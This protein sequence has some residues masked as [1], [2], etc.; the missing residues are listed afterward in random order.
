MPKAP[1][2]KKVKATDPLAPKGDGSFQATFVHVTIPTH[3]PFE[4]FQERFLGMDKV[5]HWSFVHELGTK[6]IP[7]EH[8]H[9]LMHF[10]KQRTVSSRTFDFGGQHG[11]NKAVTSLE[12]WHNTWDYHKKEHIFLRQSDPMMKDSAQQNLMKAIKDLHERVGATAAL[13]MLP[14]VDGIMRHM[15]WGKEFLATLGP[16]IRPLLP[17]LPFQAKIVEFVEKPAPGHQLL[18]VHSRASSIGKST[19]MMYM[20]Q[21]GITLITHGCSLRHLVNGYAG[22][23]VIFYNMPRDGLVPDSAYAEIETLSDGLIVPNGMYQ[24]GQRD[25]FGAWLVITSNYPPDVARLPERI[26]VMDLNVGISE[27]QI[28]WTPKADNGGVAA[29]S[30]VAAGAGIFRMPGT[31]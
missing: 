29:A 12:H 5:K 10:I 17:I 31:Y 4:A 22:Q 11:N 21:K 24:G 1:K 25:F 28:V 8:T 30:G 18:W 27:A 6:D 19:T 14:T 13:A 16:T 26:W 2:V 23:R 9:V 20:I 3:L 7:Y 15:N